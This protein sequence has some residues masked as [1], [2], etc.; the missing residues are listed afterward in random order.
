MFPSHDRVDLS[1]VMFDNF[2]GNIKSFPQPTSEYPWRTQS[3]M[4]DANGNANIYQGN[5]GYP[6]FQFTL[7]QIVNNQPGITPLP[8][9]FDNGYDTGGTSNN[10]FKYDVYGTWEYPSYI[11]T[12]SGNPLYSPTPVPPFPVTIQMGKW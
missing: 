8:D 3:W 4:Q 10:T 5:T 2:N 6:F 9:N 12:P 11:T 1:E 7:A